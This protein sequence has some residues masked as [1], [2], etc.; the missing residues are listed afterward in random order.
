MK[1]TKKLLDE[2]R[3]LEFRPLAAIKGKFGDTRAR[4]IALARSQKKLLAAIAALSIG[5]SMTARLE[6]LGICPAAMPASTWKSRC[7]GLTA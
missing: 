2:Y 4:I 6:R 5:H 7:G 3:F 1:K